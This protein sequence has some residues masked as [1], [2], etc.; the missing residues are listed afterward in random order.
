M[1]VCEQ[2]SADDDRVNDND[3]SYNAC[4]FKLQTQTTSLLHQQVL[5]S[6]AGPPLGRTWTMKATHGP[7]MRISRSR[8]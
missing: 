4:L 3:P 7:A 1:H 6:W 2:T 8:S 5:L